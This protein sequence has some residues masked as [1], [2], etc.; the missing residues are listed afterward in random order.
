MVDTSLIW[1][2]SSWTVARV[3][4]KLEFCISLRWNGFTLESLHMAWSYCICTAQCWALPWHSFP[5]YISHHWTSSS[6]ICPW[7]LGPG[8][9]LQ[10]PSFWVWPP[11]GLTTPGSSSWVMPP[12]EGQGKDS[13]GSWEMFHLESGLH[14]PWATFLQWN[15]WIEQSGQEP[16][17]WLWDDPERSLRDQ[18]P[19]AA[20]E[21]HKLKFKGTG[22]D[23]LVT[24]PSP[25]I[26]LCLWV[27]Q[28]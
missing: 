20:S 1:L 10:A 4:E 23:D 15:L 22:S 24:L 26:C 13:L 11:L 16:K 12:S 19:L 14:L 9:L 21:L 28:L 6:Q 18:T 17:F 8:F 7:T 2:L 27:W 5:F 25:L 3:T